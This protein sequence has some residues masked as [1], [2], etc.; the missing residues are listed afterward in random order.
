MTQVSSAPEQK[1][2]P[3]AVL[4][5]VLTSYLMI[6]LDISIVITGLPEIRDGLGF[7]AVG[8]SWVQNA[9]MLFFGGFLLI[10]ARAGDVLGR[11]RMFVAGLTLFTAASLVIGLA[12]TPSVLIVSRAAQGI[13]AA[14]LAPS[15]LALISITFPEGEARTKALAYYS[16]V[17]GVG[18][19]LGLVLGGVFADQISWRVGFLMNVPM[20]IALIWAAHRVLHE[21]ERQPGRSD[22][23]GAAS[24]TL[25]IGALVYG[26][27][28]AAEA[29]WGD[30]LTLGCVAV[31][32]MLIA[33]F[34]GIEARAAQPVLPL[35]LFD[36]RVRV[37]GYLARALFLSA[38]VSFFFF[39][40]QFMQEVLHF[41]PLLA[42]IGFLPM[43]LPTFATAMLVPRYTARFGNGALLTAA[44]LF[45]A[46]G[47]FWL[48]MARADAGYWAAVALPMV[49]IGVGNGFALG[50]L[51]VAGVSG[52]TSR[53]AGAA[54]GL[55]NVAHQMGG[56]LGLSLLMVVFANAGHTGLSE[57]ALRA[58]R[59]GA[60]ITGG[61]IFLTLA[62]LFTLILIVRSGSRKS[63]TALQGTPS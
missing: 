63:S 48:G 12:P 19:S 11:K 47:M 20:G 29:G 41:S 44:L 3:G 31:A 59:I 40:T 13:G 38:M 54:S 9:Y 49:L 23:A 51:T 35:R 62:T 5:I 60:A 42:G 37:G 8:L 34:L 26:I 17:A 53:D 27:V 18:A 52:V 50:P 1:A 10:A 2:R 28:H 15:V 56:A 7:S 4:T 45:G 58:E 32:L 6:V 21:T 16:M 14:I 24:S 36:S 61:G 22:I 55:V 39:T 46:V 57:A 30:P 25:G 33:L 43:T